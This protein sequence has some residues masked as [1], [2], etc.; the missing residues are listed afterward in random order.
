MGGARSRGGRQP[1]RVVLKAGR[2]GAAMDTG[3]REFQR[4]TAAGKKEYL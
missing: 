4:T 3:G 1:V 2:D